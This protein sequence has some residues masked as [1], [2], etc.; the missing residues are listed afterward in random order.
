MHGRGASISLPCVLRSSQFLCVHWA[1]GSQVVH[2]TTQ[3]PVRVRRRKVVQ[4]ERE[5]KVSGTT[6]LLYWLNPAPQAAIRTKTRA[7]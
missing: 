1:L 6:L 3:I 7:A 2:T 5:H 4:L